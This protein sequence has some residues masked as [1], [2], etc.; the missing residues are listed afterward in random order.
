MPTISFQYKDLCNLV[1]EKIKIDELAKLLE[2][3][4]TELDNYDEETDEIT[5]SAGDTNL[6]YLW[7]VEGIARLIKGLKGKQKGIPKFEVF[8]KPDNKLIVD[9]SVKNIRSHISAFV[10]KGHKVDEEEK[11]CSRCL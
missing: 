7:S 3:G 9:S 10:A 6:P 1:G 4:K 8:K 2:Y 11:S 5:V